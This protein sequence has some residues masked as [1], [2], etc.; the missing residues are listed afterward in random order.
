MLKLLI[1]CKN[2]EA[3][4]KLIN[5]V[6]FN[7]NDTRII[8]LTDNLSEANSILKS[9]EPELIICTNPDIIYLI[10]NKF[11]NYFPNIIFFTTKKYRSVSYKPIVIINPEDK[12]EF[13]M[14]KILKFLK[15]NSFSQKE[16]AAKIL[17]YLGFDFKLSGTIYLLDSILYAH[18]YK[19]SYSFEKLE[20]D[21]YSYVA[22]LN[23]TSVDRVKW[24]V[25]RTINYMYSK[26]TDE[27][28]KIVEKYFNLEYKSKPTPKLVISLI[29]NNLDK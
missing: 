2:T 4:K 15:G 29:A 20:R 3:A 17:S 24:S 18:T 5:K 7:L 25:F 1:L 8:G 19:G 16:K 27:S 14:S 12:I 23:S 11:I 21:I 26:H 10:Q 13:I 9:S 28:Y 6:A 22:N